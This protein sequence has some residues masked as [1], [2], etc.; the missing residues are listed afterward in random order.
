MKV[1]LTRIKCTAT[2]LIWVL[3][4]LLIIPTQ[5]SNYVLCI[6]EDGHIVFEIS[7]NGQCADTHA[8]NLEHA[9][10]SHP[11]ITMEGDHCGPCIDLRIFPTLDTDLHLMSANDIPTHSLV[12]SFALL[13]HQKRTSTISTFTYPQ[14]TSPLINPTLIYLQTTT[15][16]I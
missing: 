10:V 16:L 9:E 5:L 11:E 4:Y 6:G 13:T 1:S 8:F 7:I 14:H 15:L 2:P 3:F 12:Q